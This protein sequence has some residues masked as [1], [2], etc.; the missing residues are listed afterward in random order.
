MIATP[1][2]AELRRRSGRKWSRMADDVLP[3]WI[4]DMDFMPAPAILDAVREATELGDFGYGPTGAD[5]GVPEAFA[6]WAERRWGWR[7]DPADLIVMPDVMSGI[8]NCI[9]ALT[10]PGDA[11]LV[12]TPAYPPLLSS[13]RAAGRELVEH[14]LGA[15]GRIDLDGL[16]ATVTRR[17]VRLLLLCHPHN[18]TGR[19]FDEAELSAVAKIADRNNVLVVADEVHADLTYSETAHRPFAPFLPRRTVTLN[20]PSKAFNVAGLRTAVCIAPMRLRTR[21]AAL[22]PTRWSAFSTIGLRAARAAWSP[23]GALWLDACMA[24]LRDRRDRLAERIAAECPAIVLRKPQAG[25]LAWLD[26]RALEIGDPAAFFLDRAR[27]ALSPGPD[28]GAAGIGFARL[29]FATSGEIL[30]KILDRMF[31]ALPR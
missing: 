3:A 9:E 13:V 5:S 28:F 31:A 27:V 24:A 23:A 26:C 18:P 6:D 10:R 12:Q 19:S 8:A 17:G 25:Y 21:L 15:D 2:P 14:P 22:P 29:N 7:I 20:A 1:T 4:A 11:I 30:D 16:A